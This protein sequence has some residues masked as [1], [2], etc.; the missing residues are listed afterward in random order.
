MDDGRDEA[1]SVLVGGVGESLDGP[2]E[3]CGDEEVYVSCRGGSFDIGEADVGDFGAPKADMNDNTMQGIRGAQ[4]TS[5]STWQTSG[6]THI[7]S[8]LQ[9]VAV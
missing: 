3:C 1:R 5:G 8:R 9:P 2:A 7:E 6:S 4:G